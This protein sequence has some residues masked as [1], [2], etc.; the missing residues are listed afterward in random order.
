MGNKSV[1]YRGKPFGAIKFDDRFPPST[2]F[3]GGM[4]AISQMQAIWS[5]SSSPAKSGRPVSS[6]ARMHPRLHMS[7]GTP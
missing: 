2:T 5:A 1:T 7:M 6:S 3:D 4:P